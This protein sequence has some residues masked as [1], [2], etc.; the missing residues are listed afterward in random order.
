MV[1]VDADMHTSEPEVDVV[2]VYADGV[3]ALEPDSGH[4]YDSGNLELSWPT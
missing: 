4:C 2:V 1:G 3:N